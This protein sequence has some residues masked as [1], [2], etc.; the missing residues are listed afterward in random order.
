MNAIKHIANIVIAVL[1][2][3]ANIGID[4]ATIKREV[5]IILLSFIGGS[6]KAMI[7]FNFKPSTLLL[8]T[9]IT[10]ESKVQPSVATVNIK[11]KT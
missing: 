10:I 4:N 11:E 2:S 8:L 7:S 6:L 5:T 3:N 9:P 1:Q